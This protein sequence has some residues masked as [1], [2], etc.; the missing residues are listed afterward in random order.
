[1]DLNVL[2]Q[3]LES[4]SI[5]NQIEVYKIFE[6]NEIPITENNNGCFIN[7]TNLNKNIIQEINDFL[8]Y[9]N[10]QEKQ[11]CTIEEKKKKLQDNFIT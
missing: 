11:L 6:K 1:M 8:D 7:I 3:K 2:K 9:I 4:L 10:N 5:N